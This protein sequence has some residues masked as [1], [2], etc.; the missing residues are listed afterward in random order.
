M[1][2]AWIALLGLA[3][4]GVVGLDYQ[5][6]PYDWPDGPIYVAE[7]GALSPSECRGWQSR[8]ARRA[9][10]GFPGSWEAFEGFSRLQG[11]CHPQDRTR[12]REMIEAA[13][14]K[15]AGRFL[16]V[17]YVMALRAAG[18]TAR[19]AAEFPVAVEVMRNRLLIY[20]ARVPSSWRPIVVEAKAE[21]ERLETLRDWN[22]LQAR[23]DYLLGRPPLLF[24]VES[25]STKRVLWQM[26]AVDYPSAMF[27]S[28]RAFRAGKL[29]DDANLDYLGLAAGCGHI[30]AIRLQ[31]RLIIDGE[32]S[33]N[34]I[35]GA[36][37]SLVWLDSRTGAEGELLAALSAMSRAIPTDRRREIDDRDRWIATRCS[38]QPVASSRPSRS[39]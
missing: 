18:E 1:N 27:Q 22:A 17:E 34:R 10:A 28:Y 25:M 13:I 8:A 29:P 35:W 39:W 26:R 2:R 15:G 11:A 3:A 21:I 24:D 20:V 30:A 33:I 7:A 4:L 37:A 14:A 38:A 19:A 12:G 36:F 16:A 31:A 9:Q 23:L 32:L 6:R 5:T